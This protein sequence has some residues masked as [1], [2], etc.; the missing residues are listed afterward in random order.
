MTTSKDA[1]RSLALMVYLKCLINH[2]ILNLLP[3]KIVKFNVIIHVIIYSLTA[4]SMESNN[5]IH[6]SVNLV[7]KVLIVIK[8]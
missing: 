4:I 1:M 8:M 5:W 3:L 7:K 2:V 6:A